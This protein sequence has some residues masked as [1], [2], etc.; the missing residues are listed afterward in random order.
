MSPFPSD[1]KNEHQGALP[2]GQP[3]DGSVDGWIDSALEQALSPHSVPGQVPSYQAILDRSQ[4]SLF[5]TGQLDQAVSK[6]S[7]EIQSIARGRRPSV[8]ASPFRWVAAAS[9][10][11]S[12]GAIGM[13][14]WWGLS[15]NQRSGSTGVVSKNDKGG[16]RDSTSDRESAQ[17]PDPQGVGPSNIAQSNPKTDGDSVNPDRRVTQ[18]V[19]QSIDKQDVESP[20]KD[21]VSSVDRSIASPSAQPETNRVA[22]NPKP[23]EPSRL[24]LGTSGDREVIA[25]IDSQFEQ[26]WKQV[27]LMEQGSI[28]LDFSAE[29]IA[30]LLLNRVPTNSEL[31]SLRRRRQSIEGGP[32]SIGSEQIAEAW[33]SSDEFNKVWADRLADF[34]LGGRVSI[35]Q[36]L[37]GFKEWL[38]TLIRQDTAVQEIQRQVLLGLWDSAHPASFLRDHWSQ[39]TDAMQ[40][41]KLDWV[42]VNQVEGK[43]LKG[44]TQLFLHA[45]GNTAI[46]CTQCHRNDLHR[47]DLQ[48]DKDWLTGRLPAV[49]DAPGTEPL[50]FDSIAALL[51]GS[52]QPDRKELFSKLDDDRLSKIAAR[53][54]DGRRVGTE[55][56]AQDAIGTWVEQGSHSQSGVVKSLWRDF[57]GEELESEFGFDSEVSVQERSD[58]VE[59]L[60]KQAVDRRAGVRQIVYWMLMSQPARQ[61]EEKLG[62]WQF[63]ALDSAKLKEYSARRGLLKS[64]VIKS[65][66]SSGAQESLPGSNSKA[67]VRESSDE[68]TLGAFAAKVFPLQPQWLD[69]SMLAQP[70]NQKVPEPKSGASGSSNAESQWSDSLLRTELRFRVAGQQAQ[71]WAR[72]LSESKLTDAQIIAHAYMILKHRNPTAEELKAWSDS[73]WTK[74]QRYSAVLRLLAGIDSRRQ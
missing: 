36:P 51:V 6:A 63:M 29:R 53:L 5:T 62:Y 2:L 32:D 35:G 73:S 18:S 26:M 60:A 65:P 8:Q 74:S 34:Y 16:A 44:L 43:R 47:N 56:T 22:T 17:S 27:G 30:R 72:Q 67:T 20:M 25:V 23:T 46:A 9:L 58:L 59:Y 24:Q 1:N 68:E 42:G 41:E 28:G 66:S 19:E 4:K 37:I 52:V 70:S 61:P 69:R 50:V 31:E 11:A 15:P 10:A 71:R 21:Q 38:E 13:V 49:A 40:A 57:F 45:T 39:G 33:L 12:I 3:I 64:L 54:P 14:G 7:L 48:G 55:R